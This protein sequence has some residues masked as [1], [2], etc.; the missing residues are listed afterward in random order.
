MYDRATQALSPAEGRST[1][2]LALVRKAFVE[3]GFDGASMQD[4]ARAAGM[5]VGNFYRYFPSKDAIIEAMVALDMDEVEEEFATI[6]RSANPMQALRDILANRITY[7]GCDG[8]DSVLWAEITAAALRK[9]R[10]AEVS[11]RMERAIVDK[12]VSV[13]HL[14]LPGAPPAA[15]QHY[16]IE[17]RALIMLVKACAMQTGD[18]SASSLELKSR[19]Q[20]MID[21]LLNSL[22]KDA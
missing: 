18:G 14:I 5:S 11:A 20:R 6:S 15:T 19:V 4:L 7:G 21:D 17:A 12:L 8:D 1:E 9:P 10:I 3:K 2:I 13:F 16:A 22:S